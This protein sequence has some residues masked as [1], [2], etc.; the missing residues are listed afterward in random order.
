MLAEL[1]NIF[2]RQFELTES[3]HGQQLIELEA[4]DTFLKL[5]GEDRFSGTSRG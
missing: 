5:L 3:C 2:T 1:E 4:V